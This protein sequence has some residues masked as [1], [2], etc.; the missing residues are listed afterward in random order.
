MS[1]RDRNDHSGGYSIREEPDVLVVELWGETSGQHAEEI[2]AAAE[3]FGRGRQPVF[4]LVLTGRLT[5]VQPEARRAFSTMSTRVPHRMT[6]VVGASFTVR[7]IVTLAAKAGAILTGR[8]PR[9]F[10]FPSE[11]AVRA[12]LDEPLSTRS[13]APVA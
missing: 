1:F 5:G 6:L 13:P 10:F 9:V 8:P 2:L 7:T 4:L 3:R 12:W 11:Q